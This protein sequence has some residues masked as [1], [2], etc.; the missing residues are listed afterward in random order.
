MMI[1]A[2][3]PPAIDSKHVFMAVLNAYI[4]VY[5][6]LTMLLFGGQMFNKQ[7]K[8]IRYIADSSYS[9]YMI[10][11]PLLWLIQFMLLDT[12]YPLVIEFLISSMGTVLMGLIRYG[13]LVRSTPTG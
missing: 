1:T 13:I 7:S 8:I 3:S 4:S 6:C 5:V 11:L 2:G 9:F 10:H 12:D